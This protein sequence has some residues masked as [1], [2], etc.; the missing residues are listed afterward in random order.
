LD[1]NFQEEGMVQAIKQELL[2]K[3]PAI[4]D[5]MN[6]DIV[7]QWLQAHP[8]K[9][10]VNCMRDVINDLRQQILHDTAGRCGMQHITSEFV[11]GMAHK[12]LSERT[13]PHL[14]RAV[15]ATGI[16][17]HTGLG[18]AIWPT[19]V[20]DDIHDDLKGYVTLAI[21]EQTG[22]RCERDTKVSDI[23]C[24]LTGAEAA[25]VV[26]NNAAA[27]MLALGAMAE[28]KEVIVSRGQLIEIGGSFR[29]P[30]VMEQS[31]C[32]LVEVGATNR[33]HLRD[34]QNAITEKTVAI[35]RAHPSNYRIVGFTSS[36]DIADLVGLAHQHDLPVIDDLGAGA[37][38]DL[39][40]YS[41][42]HEPTVQNSVQADADIV[43]F[44]ADKLIGAAQ[45]GIIVG[46]EKFVCKCRTH[47]LYRA[48]RADKSS[49]M[50][51]ERTLMLFRDR[52]KLNREHPLY[53]MLSLSPD[54]L[55]KTAEEL[56]STITKSFSKAI[57]TVVESAGFLGSGSLPMEKLSGY[58]V[59]VSVA[60]MS[61][62]SLAI[63]LRTGD[64]PIFTRISDDKVI[65]DV[66]TLL[67]DEIA[68]IAAAFE[69][70]GSDE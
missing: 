5:L 32:K 39:A 1:G 54:E 26:N 47:P 33:T 8:R 15:N 17:L 14:R 41:L 45:G 52:E 24:E 30:E 13:R 62:E 38:V 10:V 19:C 51:L 63:K 70:I 48:F 66:R 23:L 55:K 9:L 37:L 59:S 68:K 28:D 34:Y 56:R 31:R 27:T 29:L 44:S 25:L 67:P 36:V 57:T 43:L 16:I 3:L 21:D 61:A 50:V 11:L 18:R 42:P 22:N 46:K 65:L 7:T 35:F 4:N 20:V 12:Y 60:D 2:R 6:A 64:T 40:D 53:M 58:G 69:K 49:L